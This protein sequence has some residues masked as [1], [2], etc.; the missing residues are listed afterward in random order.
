M[1]LGMESPAPLAAWV[2]LGAALLALAAV[3]AGL[4]LTRRRDGPAPPP[5]PPAPARSPG[6]RWAVDDLP[7]FLEAPPGTPGPP[8]RGAAPPPLPPVPAGPDAAPR[9]V[10]GLAAAVLTLVVVLAGLALGGGAPTERAA[11]APPAATAPPTTAPPAAPT[12]ARP[13]LPPVP[14]DPLPGERGAGLLAAR[15]V[16][17]GRDGATARLALGGLVLEQRAVGV[18]VGYPSVSVSVGT[19]GTALA[20]LRLPAWNCLGTTAP[21]DPRAAGCTSTGT[22]YADLP[23]PALGVTRDGGA[24]R[25][26]GRFPTYVRP[27]ATPPAYTGRVYDL[28]VTVAPDGPAVDGEAPAGGALFLGTERAE[29]LPDPLLSRIRV[30]G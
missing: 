4:L 14:T 18:T 9:T 20:H 7:G 19:D 13:D 1:L 22:E 30:A 5:A 15:S 6:P 26:T 27:S 10:A 16:P 11:G 25:L 2:V 24:L 29:A 12:T 17:L 8:P 28:T 21:A 23:S 3:V